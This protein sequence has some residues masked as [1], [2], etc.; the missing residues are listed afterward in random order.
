MKAWQMMILASLLGVLCA[1][2]AQSEWDNYAMGDGLAN[3]YVQAILEDG[4]GTLWFST[5]GGA[6]CY[7]EC[8]GRHTRRRTV[9]GT[10]MCGQSWR[11][12]PAISGSGHD[13]E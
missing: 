7:E 4:S 3:N 10:T 11:M 2:P 6:S 9:L 1:R 12:M 13:L 8:P 5:L